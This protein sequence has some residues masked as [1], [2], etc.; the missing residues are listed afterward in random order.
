MFGRPAVLVVLVVVIGMFAVLFAL[1]AVGT[2]A[3]KHRMASAGICA[4]ASDDHCLERVP[5]YLDGPS[6]KKGPGSRWALR[7]GAEM[8]HG[9]DSFT[10]PTQQSL[11]LEAVGGDTVVNGLA[12]DRDI[13]AVE[14]PDKTWVKTDE[15][16]DSGWLM[17]AL[18]AAFSLAGAL[19]T[20]DQLAV[21]R[22]GGVRWWSAD[23]S[24]VDDWT[25]TRW[26]A[27]GVLFFL[28]SVGGMLPLMFAG[29]FVGALVG[30]GTG[31]L[32][33]VWA[34]TAVWRRSARHASTVV[35]P[36]G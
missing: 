14:L 13:V 12:W 4:T 36:R 21:R 32:L 10:M 23:T 35:R 29:S 28:T 20:T 18:F 9:F 17:F 19:V 25:S 7:D 22:R 34:M 30:T 26:M 16:G 24:V 33:G 3:E 11:E 15:F 8:A 6:F 27:F 2:Y 31:L 5:G 1:L